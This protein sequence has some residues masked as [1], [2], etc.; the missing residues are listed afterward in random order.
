MECLEKSLKDLDTDY[1][2][3]YQYHFPDVDTPAEETNRETKK[4]TRNGIIGE[5]VTPETSKYIRL[6]LR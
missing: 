5:T 4:A 1:L 6:N 2:D 3:L